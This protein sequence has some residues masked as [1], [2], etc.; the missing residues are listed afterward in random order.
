MANAEKKKAGGGIPE[1]HYH[2]AG[3]TWTVG[4]EDAVSFKEAGTG[5]MIVVGFSHS[6]SWHAAINA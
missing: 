1:H 4:R 2:A 3:Q 6:R 5:K